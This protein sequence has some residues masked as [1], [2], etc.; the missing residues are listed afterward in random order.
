MSKR[1]SKLD[2]LNVEK[3]C[4][5]SWEQMTGTA[6]KRFCSECNKH[7]FDFSQMTC[8]QIEAVSAVHQGNLCARITRR[9]DGSMVMLEPA[10]PTYST[11]RL[12]L[13]VLNAAVATMLTLSV[14]AT[15]QQ[16]I[17]KQGEVATPQSHKGKQKESKEQPPSGGT[18]S[19]SGTVVDPQQLV[20]A[21]AAVTLVL[22]NSQQLTTRS[23]AE[24]NF[25]FTGLAPGTYTLTFEFQ[26]F[27]TTVLTDVRTIANTETPLS[28]TMEI[29]SAGIA[30]GVVVSPPATLLNLYRD[31]ELIAIVTVGPSNVTKVEESE[32][33]LQTTLRISS[34][35]KGDTRQLA[36]PFYHWVSERNK[37]E[38]K[39][40]DRLLV[41]LDQRRSEDGKP[42]NGFETTDWSRS[43]KKLDDAELG[44]YRQRIEEL[45]F[46]LASDQPNRHELVEWM[47]RCI[48]E[49]ATRWDGAVE[50]EQQMN[51]IEGLDEKE[52]ESE[53]DD[54]AHQSVAAEIVRETAQAKSVEREAPEPDEETAVNLYSLMTK[55]QK[56]RVSNVL[57][58][59]DEL[60]GESWELVNLVKAWDSKRLVPYLVAQLQKFASEAPHFAEEIVSTLAELSNDQTIRDAAKEYE[61]GIEY[62]DS[63]FQAELG[64][65]N[66]KS[67][68]VAAQIAIS[69][70]TAKLAK[71]LAVINQKLSH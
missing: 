15:A 48:E 54:Q 66:S 52:E 17:V 56:A 10:L 19:I 63:E 8:Q 47:V 11:H 4:S 55:E 42:I 71:F 45:N 20:I 9:T 27:R 43:I 30:G 22:P 24:G 18:S 68:S 57:F 40:G 60:S 31:S 53:K 13:P 69:K 23:S 59:I 65:T 49:P 16:V 14:P 64:T 46:I 51:L 32:K 3:P 39:S 1:K 12:N 25:Q 38:L 37:D 29:N 6:Q 61:E 28:V 36:V 67:K 58:S 70:R 41:F 21:N 35:L 2:L 33:Q 34:I 62:D 44:V 26:G 7:V 50:L 5:A